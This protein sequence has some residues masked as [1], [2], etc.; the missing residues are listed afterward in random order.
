[1]IQS[2]ETG[3]PRLTARQSKNNNFA[4]RKP[5]LGLPRGVLANFSFRLCLVLYFLLSSSLFLHLC[6]KIHKILTRT[7]ARDSYRWV[8]NYYRFYE[9]VCDESPTRRATCRKALYEAR[10]CANACPSSSPGV[11][12]EIFARSQAARWSPYVKLFKTYNTRRE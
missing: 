7:F 2:P 1:M 8:I 11:R 10:L 6:R 9:S 5:R 12:C 3:C 4:Q